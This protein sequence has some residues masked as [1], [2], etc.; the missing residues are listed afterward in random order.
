[1]RFEAQESLVLTDPNLWQVV[2]SHYSPGFI[3]PSVKEPRAT[4]K[5]SSSFLQIDRPPYLELNLLRR[6]DV[7]QT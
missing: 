7:R 2:A 1:M 4:V 3:F 6:F 5:V